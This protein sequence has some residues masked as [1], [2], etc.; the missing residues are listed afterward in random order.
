MSIAHAEILTQRVHTLE[1][2]YENEKEAHIILLRKYTLLQRRYR[3]LHRE[4]TILSRK[5]ATKSA[6]DTP[7]DAV[8]SRS[9][10]T[11]ANSNVID[12]TS[13]SPRLNGDTSDNVYMST[14]DFQ[15]QSTETD[16]AL[17]CGPTR[18]NATLQNGQTETGITSQSSLRFL[19]RKQDAVAHQT[20]SSQEST[21]HIRSVSDQEDASIAL[22]LSLQEEESFA[23]EE[24]EIR[25]QYAMNAS[26]ISSN[27]IPNHG[28]LTDVNPDAM[29]YEE[30]LELGERVGDVKKDRW[31]QIAPSRV[32]RLPSCRWKQYM[33]YSSCIICQ[34]NFEPNDH[35]LTLPC[36]HIFHSSC[37]QG[38]LLENSA[39]PLCKVE[40]E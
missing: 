15:I 23:L 34:H 29:T 8:E 39:C 25:S 3:N 13:S 21:N 12:L 4:Y 16:S 11:V 28:H 30:L 32:A 6:I 18:P 20:E 33:G 26:L 27:F 35:A 17:L 14:S 1:Q 7:S 19:E 22:A 10:H 37:V 5:R 24:Y 36:T 31:R 38:W 9:I 2:A 40:I